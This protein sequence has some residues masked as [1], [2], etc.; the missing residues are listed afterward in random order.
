[1]RS[2]LLAKLPTYFSIFGLFVWNRHSHLLHI[3]W[4]FN[5]DIGTFVPSNSNAIKNHISI[6]VS[7]FRVNFPSYWQNTWYWFH[8]KQSMFE[9]VGN[10]KSNINSTT[11]SNFLLYRQKIKS[12]SEICDFI[13]S[14]A[15][16]RVCIFVHHT[17][18]CSIILY[19]LNWIQ[20]I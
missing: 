2:S 8:N 15:V 7:I 6:F 1:M 14:G 10:T 16:Q 13:A 5:T 19:V 12:F 20:R 3:M 18:F 17:L 4:Y 9:S 11:N